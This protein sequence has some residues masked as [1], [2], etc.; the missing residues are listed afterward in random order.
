MAHLNFQK[1]NR[2][3]ERGVNKDIHESKIETQERQ[4]LDLLRLL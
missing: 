2:W 1:N 4:E 3:W